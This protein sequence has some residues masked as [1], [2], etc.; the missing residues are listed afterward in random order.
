M[1]LLSEA[2]EP[3][4]IMDKTTEKDG[5]GGVVTVWKEGAEIEA[6]IVQDGGIEQLTAQQR[7]WNGSYTVITPRTII[8]MDGDVFKRISDGKMFRV[9]SDGTDD[10][11]PKSAGLDMRKVKAEGFK[12]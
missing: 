3:C 2:Y 6:A 9:T 11:T 1:S 5:Y 7:G 10:K 8:F 12:P 4:V